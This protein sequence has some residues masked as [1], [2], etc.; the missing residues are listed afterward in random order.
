VL[1]QDLAQQIAAS[2][3][4]KADGENEPVAGGVVIHGRVAAVTNSSSAA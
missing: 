4:G 3:D 2:Q 1:A